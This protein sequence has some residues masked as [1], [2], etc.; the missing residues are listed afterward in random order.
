M[1]RSKI[2]LRRRYKVNRSSFLH[3]QRWR[4]NKNKD[5]FNNTSA[6]KSNL[7]SSTIQITGIAANKLKK[8]RS[9]N[10]PRCPKFPSICLLSISSRLAWFRQFRQL[11]RRKMSSRAMTKVNKTTNNTNSM[12]SK[13]MSL[14]K[15]K[16]R[17][18]LSKTVTIK[19]APPID[20]PLT[21]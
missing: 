20:H 2:D 19:S 11:S 21:D 13:N 1:A 8:N 5:N 7:H 10:I 15:P 18:T 12:R 16:T 4:R 3:C 9:P 17:F 6:Y 14:Q